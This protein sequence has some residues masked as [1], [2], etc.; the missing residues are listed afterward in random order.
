[1]S[2]SAQ[3]SL[4]LRPGERG[5]TAG[6]F[7]IEDV[8][9]SLEC[10]RYPV[11][12]PA[13]ETFEVWADVFRS[14]HDVVAAELIWRREGI[15]AWRR[16]P[17]SFAENDRWVGRFTPAEPGRY[18]YAVEAWTDTFASW[19]HGFELKSKAEQDV[20]LDALE[21]AALL[22][23]PISA[24]EQ[25][26][27]YVRRQ[28]DAY[29]KTGNIDLLLSAELAG[30]LTASQ[31]RPDLTRSRVF[32]LVID[33]ERAVHGAWYEMI[34]RSQSSVIA[35]NRSTENTCTSRIAST[36]DTT[37]LRLDRISA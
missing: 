35:P 3:K 30:L 22:A 26:T 7:L 13:G 27:A 10:G 16:T 11:K 15:S 14:G 23:R 4:P 8:Y 2:V 31:E 9:P 24:D 33:R 28:L 29:L 1:M 21:G 5:A 36:G 19:K 25:T 32:P 34:P 12:R 18:E 17:M 37:W 20:S 6:A